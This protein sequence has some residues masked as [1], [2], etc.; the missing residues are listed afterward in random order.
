[1][2]IPVTV[3]PVTVRFGSV[4]DAL[5]GAEIRVMLPVPETLRPSKT[6]RKTPVLVELAPAYKAGSTALARAVV[7]WAATGWASKRDTATTAQGRP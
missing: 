3:K 4:P 2:Y 7:F 1:M 5:A 6:G